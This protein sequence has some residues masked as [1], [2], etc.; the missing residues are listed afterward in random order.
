MKPGS[1]TTELAVVVAVVAMVISA[2]YWGFTIPDA[3]WY[4]LGLSGGGYAI[5]RG[6]AKMN[7]I[8]G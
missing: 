8:K 2:G 6:L 4:S 7:G 1:K 3:A 5:G